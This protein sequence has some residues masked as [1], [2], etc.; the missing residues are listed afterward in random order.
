VTETATATVEL[1]ADDRAALDSCKDNLDA[2]AYLAAR[3][4]VTI[5]AYFTITTQ[6]QG[7]IPFTPW[8][9]Q[10]AWWR[11]VT[12]R[13]MIG[14]SRDIGSSH[15]V[16]AWA[17]HQMAFLGYPV[18]IVGNREKTAKTLLGYAR[19]FVR[20]IQRGIPGLLPPVLVEN[21]TEIQFGS[22]AS[23]QPR[24]YIMALPAGE[25]P[26]RSQRAMIGIMSEHAAVQWAPDV[27]AGFVGAIAPGGYIV[28]ESTP[29]GMYSHHGQMWFDSANGYRKTRHDWRANPNHTEEW[30]RE[31]RRDMGPV[32]FAQEYEVEF[33]QSGRPF[34]SENA[35]GFLKNEKPIRASGRDELGTIAVF[36][37]PHPAKHYFGGGDPSGGESDDCN[38]AVHVVFDNAGNQVAELRGRWKPDRFAVLVDEIARLYPG[39]HLIEKEN[40]GAAVLLELR[41][42]NTPGIGEWQTGRGDNRT[43]MLDE[44][45]KALRL[46][47]ARI[48]SEATINEHM[49]FVYVERG[50]GKLRAEAAHGFTDDGVLASAIAFQAMTS[51]SFDTEV[52]AGVRSEW[53]TI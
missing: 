50:L 36:E 18:L 14:K 15:A 40:H 32:R 22:R 8:P 53:E 45:E 3:P 13:E 1:S 37:E 25:D 17:V 49:A 31:R 12:R 5:P 43:F 6:N 2:L 46:D 10:S 47:K 38:F 44:W 7:I 26:A 27:W 41:H 52:Y 35:P 19:Q 48:R 42:L 34:F 39:R 9:W 23:G 24:F 20:D 29:K 21:T 4:W 16:V 33:V 28:S 51:G 30:G 11:G